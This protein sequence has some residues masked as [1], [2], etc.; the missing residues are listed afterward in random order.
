MQSEKGSEELI[1]GLIER[2]SGM[3]KV[4]DVECGSPRSRDELVRARAALATE[5]RRRAVLVRCG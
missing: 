4:V 2:L 3:G 5:G 1:E